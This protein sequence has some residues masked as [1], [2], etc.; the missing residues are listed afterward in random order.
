VV[1]LW[2]QG[3]NKKHVLQPYTLLNILFIS[4]MK[5]AI[6]SV[7][8]L[9]INRLPFPKYQTLVHES[10]LGFS[11]NVAQIRRCIFYK[12][13]FVRYLVVKHV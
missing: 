10:S 6:S 9:N 12:P 13:D 2:L 11:R 8:Q 5:H 1:F 7:W 4:K 3:C